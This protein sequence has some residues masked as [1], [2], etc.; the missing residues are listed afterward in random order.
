LLVVVDDVVAV[1]DDD[2]LLTF[3]VEFNEFMKV[4]LPNIFRIVLRKNMYI[5]KLIDYNSIYIIIIIKLIIIITITIITIKLDLN[6]Y[7]SII[8]MLK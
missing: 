6:Q 1:D 8:N 4:V 5:I 2:G 3:D 7:L